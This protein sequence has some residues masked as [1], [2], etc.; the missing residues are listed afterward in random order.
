M[1][2]NASFERY[3][4][5]SVAKKI[6]DGISDV[7]IQLPGTRLVTGNLEEWI[8]V[9]V[10]T[11]PRQ[12]TREGIW[13]GRMV[14][15]VSCLARFAE[16]R[17]DKDSSAP[18][19]L[20]SKARAALEHQAICV[21]TYGANPLTQLASFNVHEAEMRYL[22]EGG[23]DVESEEAATRAGDVSNVHGV[24]LTFTAYVLA[25]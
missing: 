19:T 17:E 6:R 3:L 9:H 14:F 4:W 8:A 23:L 1:S 13:A 20:A 7:E 24:A 12:R 21:K 18:W 22:S 10:L 15:Q 25:K 16:D 2:V 5:L 11:I